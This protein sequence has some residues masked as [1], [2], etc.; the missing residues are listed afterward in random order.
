M[1]KR[2]ESNREEPLR[3]NPGINGIMV[4]IPI[5]GEEQL[6]K[7]Q[8]MIENALQNSATGRDTDQLISVDADG[9]FIFI[10]TNVSTGLKTKYQATYELTNGNLRL[11]TQSTVVVNS[12]QRIEDNEEIEDNEDIEDNEEGDP[13]EPLYPAGTVQ[14][15]KPVKDD[16]AGEILL[17]NFK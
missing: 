6:N 9:T 10:R 17:P 1:T 8:Q 2:N 4:N 12:A 13:G 15:R 16:E 7:V 3:Y 11:D 14:D 5:Q